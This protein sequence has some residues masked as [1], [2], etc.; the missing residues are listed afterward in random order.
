MAVPMKLSTHGHGTERALTMA[1]AAMV[2]VPLFLLAASLNRLEIKPGESFSLPKSSEVPSASP[3]I[4]FPTALFDLFL[5]LLAIA[6]VISLVILLR[7]P[8]DRRILLGNVGRSLLLAAIGLLAV[9]LYNPPE[10]TEVQVTPQGRAPSPVSGPSGGIESLGTPVPVSLEP[11]AAPGWARYAVTL[12]IVLLTGA[13]CYWGWQFAHNPK[14]Q[15]QEI[16]RSALGDLFAG[17]NWEDV[18]IRCYADMNAAVSRRRG[19]GRHQAMTPREF[20]V[21]L[22][23]IGLPASSVSRLTRLFE[24]ARYGSHQSTP[25]QVQ[26][27]SDCLAEIMAA[28]TET[29]V[30]GLAAGRIARPQLWGEGRR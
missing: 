23:Q 25:N 9:S 30:A 17:R 13:L 24:Q 2:I 22:E 1:V 20:A 6:F 5:V 14:Q 27:A 19:V 15:V 26:E 12:A 7:S 29:P 18:V 28:L 11:P 10:K 16:T 4:E 8:R 21:R 3:A